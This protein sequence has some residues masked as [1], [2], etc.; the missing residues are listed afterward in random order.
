MCPCHVVTLG[1]CLPQTVEKHPWLLSPD[2]RLPKAIS[3]VLTHSVAV[4][5]KD[6]E[7]ADFP[8]LKLMETSRVLQKE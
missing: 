2:K 3:F 8:S 1:L 4:T 6:L 5:V 7:M